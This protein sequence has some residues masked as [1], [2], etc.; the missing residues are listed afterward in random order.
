VTYRRWKAKGPTRGP[1]D[2]HQLAEIVGSPSMS[3]NLMPIAQMANTKV[4]L[5]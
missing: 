4:T 2:R 3:M 1:L 5:L